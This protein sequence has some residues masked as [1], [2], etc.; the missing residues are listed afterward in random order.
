M[1]IATSRACAAGGIA[2]FGCLGMQPHMEGGPADSGDRR[3]TRVVR[4]LRWRAVCRV[5]HH[6]LLN[7][8]SSRG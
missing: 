3:N 6:R 8:R 5:G 2:P 1:C 4:E 7:E